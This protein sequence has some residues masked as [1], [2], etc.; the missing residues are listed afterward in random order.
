MTKTKVAAAPEVAADAVL[1]KTFVLRRP[2]PGQNGKPISEITVEEPR[3][4]HAVVAGR[5]TGA[6]QQTIALLS[7]VSG[8]P[9]DSIKKLKTVDALRINVWLKT[10]EGTNEVVE[11]P[12]TGDVTLP[13][14]VPI[15]DGN[16]LITEITLREPDLEA[17]IAV[18][19]MV[20][21]HEQLAATIASLSGLTIPTV[22]QLR[23]RDV[24]AVEAWLGPLGD[25]LTSAVNEL[26]AT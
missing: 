6:N 22:N 7:A 8:V 21:Q 9:E 5:K 19:K 2:I 20:T 15:R 26:G 23:L 14:T 12:A 18:E 10:L 3:L 17:G 24:A 11:D 16:K 4:G 25:E 13:L 1:T